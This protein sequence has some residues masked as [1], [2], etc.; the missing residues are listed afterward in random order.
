MVIFG[1]LKINEM[2]EFNT[3]LVDSAKQYA[4]HHHDHPYECQR[5]GNKPYSVHLD[6]VVANAQRYLYYIK[7]EDK[8][9]VI[10]SCYFHDLIEDTIVTF[11]MLVELYGYR[12]ADLIFR[13]SNERGRDRKTVNFLTYPKIWE[14]DLA[15]FIKLMD[16]LANGRNSKETKHKQY[17]IYRE[18]YPVFRYA[19]KVRG[20]YPDAWEEAD[21]IFEYH[22]I[23]I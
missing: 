17:A 23:C 1:N 11:K 4:A 7:E 18:E 14:D 12:T 2:K 21:N 3:Q 9:M 16:R 5:Y 19:L 13:V 15:I 22:G 8:E 20:L 6:D 10:V